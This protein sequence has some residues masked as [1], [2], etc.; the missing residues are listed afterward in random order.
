MSITQWVQ[1]YVDYA[2]WN[3]TDA[4][5]V[6]KYLDRY[7]DEAPGVI[8]PYIFNNYPDALY[9]KNVFQ[10]I[11]T[12]IK[13]LDDAEELYHS[14]SD[15]LLKEQ[16]II[17]IMS[18]GAPLLFWKYFNPSGARVHHEYVR[19]LYT[20]LTPKQRKIYAVA[21]LTLGGY[22]L[23]YLTPK[24]RTLKLCM[25]AVKNDGYALGYVPKRKRTDEIVEAAVSRSSSAMEYA[26]EDQRIKFIELAVMGVEKSGLR[27][28][29]GFS[30]NDWKRP[31]AKD[32]FKVIG[33]DRKKELYKL[34]KNQRKQDANDWH[35]NFGR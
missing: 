8:I 19:E 3:L 11:I 35:N 9:N 27:R 34:W 21:A 33:V 31:W 4:Q 32:V 1:D 13:G 16:V 18:L 6:L 29:G 26:S 5:R 10:R 24:Q 12:R 30:D 25:L 14:L 28:I 2:D 20:S 15:D 23:Q 17:T 22:L 7:P